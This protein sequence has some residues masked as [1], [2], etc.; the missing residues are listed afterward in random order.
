M[1][2]P[3][4]SG[5]SSSSL[6]IT[7]S[8]PADDGYY[9]EPITQYKVEYRMQGLSTGTQVDVGTGGAYTITGL[10]FS[11]G[12]EIRIRSANA[13]GMSI[14]SDP[15]Y[16][17]TAATTPSTPAAPVLL[18]SAGSELTIGWS[19]PAEDGG[20]PIIGYKIESLDLYTGMFKDLQILGN[21]LN[22]TVSGL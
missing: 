3:V 11:Q 10:T 2:A 4:L 13:V 7:W 6:S 14:W 18:S 8:P 19:P 12:Y 16:A 15:L 20:S 5:V 9:H 1:A 17:I 21:V 22:T